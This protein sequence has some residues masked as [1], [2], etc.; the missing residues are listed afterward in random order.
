MPSEPRQYKG[1]RDD[2]HK[3]AQSTESTVRSNRTYKR[4]QHRLWCAAML[5]RL[6]DTHCTM[7][8]RVLMSTISCLHHEPALL[9]ALIAQTSLQCASSCRWLLPRGQH[10]FVC[11]L[12]HLL[13]LL[14]PP[15]PVLASCPAAILPRKQL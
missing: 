1:P 11:R 14:L 12:A 5:S 3:S 10:L 15:L 2:G 4:R 7:A 9:I 8:A 6:G 13:L